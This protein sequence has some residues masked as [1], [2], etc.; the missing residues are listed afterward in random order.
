MPKLKTRKAVV[1]KFKVSKKKKVL[2]RKTGQNHFNAKE[3]GKR[4]RHKKGYVRLFKT[5]EN[6]VKKALPYI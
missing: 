2:R 1:K 6:N 5:D 4:G 3:T